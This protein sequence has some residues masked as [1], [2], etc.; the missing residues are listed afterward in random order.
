MIGRN[1]LSTTVG[2]GAILMTLM[3]CTTGDGTGTPEG[4]EP[5]APAGNDQPAEDGTAG[6]GTTSAV[7]EPGLESTT[8][9]YW[10]EE[11]M[12]QAEPVEPPTVTEEELQRL[13][14]EPETGGAPGQTIEGAPAP[15]GASSED[16]SAATGTPTKADVKSRP[17][18]NGGK[19][20][21]TKQDGKN[22]YCSAEFVGSKRV[23]MTAGHCV[24]DGNGNWYKNFK[25]KR[26]YDNGGGQSV[27]WDCM[28]VKTAY[29]NGGDNAYDYAFIYTNTDSGAGWL[30]FK[31]GVPYTSWTSIGYP[32]AYSGGNYMYKVKGTKGSVSTRVVEM[33]DNPMEGGSSGGAWIGDLQSSKGGNYAIGLNSYHTTS[34]NEFSPYFNSTTYDL[35]VYVMD[36]KCTQ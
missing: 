4:S 35:L 7:Q 10:T 22:Y 34:S 8:E 29:F 11:R 5:T 19:F 26:A 33:L 32:K 28:S 1:V 31:T 20:F 18:W 16:A 15:E 14:S 2:L 9:E 12:Q 27:G 17:F 36:K 25:F 23:V 6:S 21:F 3:A 24:T 13:L 30:G